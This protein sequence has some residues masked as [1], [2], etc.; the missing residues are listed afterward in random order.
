MALNTVFLRTGYEENEELYMK[1]ARGEVK[2]PCSIKY[3]IEGNKKNTS[4]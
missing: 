4:I 2:K 3:E 1:K